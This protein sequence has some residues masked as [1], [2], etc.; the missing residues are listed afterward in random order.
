MEAMTEEEVVAIAESTVRAHIDAIN[1]GDVGAMR[2][3]LVGSELEKPFQ[4]YSHAMLALRPLELKEL[5]VGRPQ[6]TLRPPVP[7][8]RVRVYMELVSGNQVAREDLPVWVFGDTRKA[9]IASRILM[10]KAPTLR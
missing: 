5:R 7:R 6:A 2:E 1:R 4:V 3:Q 10:R 8:M 9:M